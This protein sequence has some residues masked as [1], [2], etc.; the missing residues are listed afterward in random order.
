MASAELTIN[1]HN[2]YGKTP[3]DYDSI[4]SAF[5]LDPYF[6]H[7][8]GGAIHIVFPATKEKLVIGHGGMDDNR[9][10]RVTLYGVP[11]DPRDMLDAPGLPA[12]QHDDDIDYEV[13]AFL[14]GP[15]AGIL[16]CQTLPNIRA[17]RQG[18]MQ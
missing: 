4:L 16:L 11:K 3:P 15:E 14:E 18:R 17:N 12:W 10:N 6:T 5:D 9:N 13:I 2:F 1:E 7:L 8:K